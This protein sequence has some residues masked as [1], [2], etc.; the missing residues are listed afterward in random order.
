MKNQI[1]LWTAALSI[2]FIFGYLNRIT[3][4]EYPV[5]GT[6]K[7]NK[8]KISYLFDKVYRGNDQ[9]KFQIFTDLKGLSGKLEFKNL[10]DNDWKEMTLKHKGNIYFA[11]L[12]QKEPGES[13]FYRAELTYNVES[14]II[15]KTE[16]VKITFWEKV[17]KQIMMFYYLS[18][19]F[20]IFLT[21]RIGL[22]Y[23][24]KNEKI[25]KLSLFPLI[26]FIFCGLLIVPIKHTYELGAFGNKIL[27]IGQLFDI[28]SLLFLIIWI[29]TIIL[30]F[31][32]KKRRIYSL[33]SAIALLLLY[34][35]NI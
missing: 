14:I 16:G 7:Y 13:I 25:K 24:N 10:N 34:G 32:S 21:T 12:P 31:N 15:P 23:F 11:F 22:E 5:T 8:E 1:I 29:V 27:Q 18:L 3:S 33:I 28:R 9:Y 35:I 26:L 4:K 2:T 30:I 19:F 17:S 20:G 6:V